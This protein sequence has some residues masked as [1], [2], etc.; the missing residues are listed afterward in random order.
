[1]KEEMG[2]ASALLIERVSKV[3]TREG[4]DPRCLARML[5]RKTFLA[6]VQGLRWQLAYRF[7]LK[8]QVLSSW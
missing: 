2:S 8:G 4:S 3:G 5:C 1:M 7:D 6:F